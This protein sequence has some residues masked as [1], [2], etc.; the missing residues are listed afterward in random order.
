MALEAMCDQNGPRQTSLVVRI[1]PQRF[2]VLIP[3]EATVE[4]ALKGIHILTVVW[5]GRYCPIIPCG[6]TPEQIECGKQWLAD[7]SPDFVCGID[8]EHGLWSRVA[9]K[10]CRPLRYHQVGHDTLHSLFRGV[11]P[12]PITA[13]AVNRHILSQNPGM[14]TSRFFHAE[15]M[16]DDLQRVAVAATYGFAPDRGGK[17]VVEKL[18]GM[19]ATHTGGTCPPPLHLLA[20]DRLTLLD[21]A[22]TG[23]SGHVYGP[24]RSVLPPTVCLLANCGADLATFWARRMVQPPNS[25]SRILPLPVTSATESGDIDE[26][27]TWLE[28]FADRANYCEV[29]A[30]P[31]L[32]DTADLLA[33][34]LRPRVTKAGIK[35]VDVHCQRT[36]PPV[37]LCSEESL[38]VPATRMGRTY[39]LAAPR[40]AFVSFLRTRD[41]WMVDLVKDEE[42][43]RAPGEGMP[44]SFRLTAHE[45]LNAPSPPMAGKAVIDGARYSTDFVSVRA[46]K[47][48]RKLRFCIPTGAELIG[49]H[50]RACGLKTKEDDKRPLYESVIDRF[51]SLY[52][53]ALSCREPFR[54]MLV[55]LKDGDLLEAQIKAKAKLGKSKRSPVDASETTRWFKDQPVRGRVWEERF[56]EYARISHP[57]ADRPLNALD[58]WCEKGIASQ[59]FLTPKC[60]ACRRRSWM[61]AIDI[62]RPVFCRDCGRSVP[63]LNSVDVGYRLDPMVSAALDDG[64]VPVALT[65]DFLHNLT[66]RGFQWVPGCH[67]VRDGREQDI[68]IMAVCDGHFVMAECKSLSGAGQPSPGCWAEIQDQ[69]SALIETARDC[70]AEVVVLAS[71]VQRYPAAIRS[72]ARSASDSKISVHL[73]TKNDLDSGRRM[74]VTKIGNEKRGV[75]LGIHDLLPKQPSCVA[76]KRKRKGKR[77]LKL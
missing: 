55:A 31:D 19:Y 20:P 22:S 3:W 26:I 4:Q 44:P 15:P 9:L 21:S 10:R 73:L 5:G 68:D 43:G 72:L 61:E 38:S 25:E 48:Q 32:A 1:R 66:S 39:E 35:H 23:L 29:V 18:K 63:V 24:L 6:E 7:L 8:V 76:A 53:A 56:R 14:T 54:A 27:A 46:G 65:G 11:S 41:S 67:V 47:K 62:S 33:R 57:N 77:E 40:P 59:V 37:V 28:T 42:T 34:K 74:G 2:A 12:D 45:V 69:F 30:T 50:I 36:A 51:G 71:L 52:Q 75:P 58:Y 70:G 16:G 17:G 49:E 60:P 64:F 13:D